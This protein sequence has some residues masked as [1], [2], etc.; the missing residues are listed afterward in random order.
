LRYGLRRTAALPLSL[1]LIREIHARLMRGAR[2]GEP[3]KTPGE[4]RR[5]QNWV[6]GPSPA[7]ARYVPPPVAEMN[8]ALDLFERALHDPTPFPVL[9]I[10][11][12]AHAQFET[13]HPFLDGNGR[14]GRLLI[15]F[16]LCE[17]KVLREP[18]L[19][20]SI[21]FK[22][23][24]QEYYD[25]LQAVRDH[26]DWE[27]WLSFFL[28]GVASV[29]REATDT[30]RQVVRLRE[31]LRGELPSKLGRRSGNG[32]RL[33]DALFQHP[34]VAVKS[35]EKLL[36][37]SQPASLALVDAMVSV[38][39]LEEVTGLRR[40]RIFEFGEYLQLFTERKRRS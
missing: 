38:G 13:I 21:F 23:H 25:R 10:V 24:R 9:V 20:L 32:L 3:S 15:T 2:G 14:M 29:A 17:Y 19:Y 5:S 7:T 8:E 27:G 35:V 18:L 22:Q 31:R 16:L 4:F 28:A 37:L 33:L 34:V 30:A 1:R 6:G 26:G 12:L 36:G 11:G 40:N 39:V